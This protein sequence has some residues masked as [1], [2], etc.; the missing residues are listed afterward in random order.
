M[1]VVGDEPAECLGVG[2]AGGWQRKAV[3][4]ED[5]LQLAQAHAGLDPERA[6]YFVDGDEAVVALQ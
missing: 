5:L 2:G 4:V 3:L 6:P 1:H